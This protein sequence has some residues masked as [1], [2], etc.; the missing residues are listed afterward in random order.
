MKNELFS[1]VDSPNIVDE[2]IQHVQSKNAGAIT[3]FMVQSAS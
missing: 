3:V 2:V 1:I